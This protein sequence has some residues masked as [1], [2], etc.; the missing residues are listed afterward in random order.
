MPASKESRSAALKKVALFAG[1]GERELNYLAD[2]AIPKNY[3][4][5]EM[6]FSEGEKCSG[7]YVIDDLVSPSVGVRG[8]TGGLRAGTRVLLLHVPPELLADLM[9][10][11]FSE[12]IIDFAQYHQ[13]RTRKQLAFIG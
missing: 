4:A 6:I 5:G 13:A 3:K 1:L 9:D 10:L 12:G 7:L 11:L 8:V 2:R